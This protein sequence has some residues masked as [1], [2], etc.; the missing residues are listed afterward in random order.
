MI[1]EPQL[2]LPPGL[3][4][5]DASHSYRLDG[6]P[7]PA[8]STLLKVVNPDQYEG[9][10]EEVMER[11]RTRGVNGHHMIALDVRDQLD[12]GSLS[13]T[14]TD[15]Y[16]AWSQFCHDYGFIPRY[17]ERCVA[18]RKHQFAGTLDLAGELTKH[19][20]LRGMWMVDVKYVAAEPQMVGPQTAGYDIAAEESIPGW[21]KN[22][23]RGCLWIR[24]STYRF[25]ECPRASDR[26]VIISAR[27]IYNYRELLK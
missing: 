10:R 11:A 12:V 23:P 20:R 19:K 6:N 13:D 22:T 15:N 26:A 5:D 16:L 9:V 21:E 1:T 14:L 24:G 3:E 17:S 27:T 7:V 4:Y 2:F 18:S 25:I 8:V